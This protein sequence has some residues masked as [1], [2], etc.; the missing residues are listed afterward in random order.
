[1][2]LVAHKEFKE[3]TS[4]EDKVILDFAGVFKEW[5]WNNINCLSTLHVC[6]SYSRLG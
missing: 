1:V 5:A 6:F 2:F 4:R 3:L